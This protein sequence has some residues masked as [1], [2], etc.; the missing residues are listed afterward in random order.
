VRAAPGFTARE[1]DLVGRTLRA[2]TVVLRVI[3]PIRRC[4]TTTYDIATGVSEPRVL[5]EVARQRENIVGVYCETVEPG[6][7][8]RGEAIRLDSTRL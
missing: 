7:L 5:G 2:D 1:A 4:V 3:E 6:M 8:A